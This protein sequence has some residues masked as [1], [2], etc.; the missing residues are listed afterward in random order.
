MLFRLT[1]SQRN[2][3]L[4]LF[5]LTDT[6]LEFDDTISTKPNATETQTRRKSE[7]KRARLTA[8]PLHSW[9]ILA[10]L[11]GLYVFL[12][13][14]FHRMGWVKRSTVIASLTLMASIFFV[15]V[16]AFKT[17][18][19]LKFQEKHLKLPVM[20]AV[21]TAMLY[22]Y[23]IEPVTQMIL[24]PFVLVFAAYGMYRVSRHSMAWLTVFIL[25]GSICV[26]F[27]HFQETQN[28]ALLSLEAMHF[29]VLLFTLPA[30]IYLSA[31]VHHLYQTLHRASRKIKGI[32]EDAKQDVLINCFNRRYMVAALEEQ[33]L[34]ADQNNT[35]LCLAV[36]DLDHFKRVN[37]QLGHLG[38]DEVLRLFSRI[39]QESVRSE[40]IF[41]RYGGEEFLLIFPGTSLLPAL[42]TSERIRTEVEAYHW[43]KNIR[44]SVT[45][46]IGVTQYIA[47][48]SVLELFSRA[49]T[50]MYLAKEGGRNQVV[51]EEPFMQSNKI[52]QI[53]VV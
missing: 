26:I 53:T 36:L 52:E 24:V 39:A 37:D 21:S 49:D 5:P 42:N 38:G 14:I 15:Y 13:Y 3:E 46:S 32:E 6:L 51:V 28:P 27:F 18:F 23:Y 29:L 25:F 2:R 30:F 50:A 11:F 12:I 17:K 1:K 8:K 48:E 16:L 44:N 22:I 47:G 41:G 31:K 34:L 35:P 20:A 19:N 10:G 9:I 45:V 43:D 40:D 33:K 7:N 4:D